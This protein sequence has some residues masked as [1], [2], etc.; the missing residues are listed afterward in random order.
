MPQ[1][2][3]LLRFPQEQLLFGKAGVP[4]G[5]VCGVFQ[6]NVSREEEPADGQ[7]LAAKA[8]RL[9]PQLGYAKRTS[10]VEPKEREDRP[11]HGLSL[12]EIGR[13][14]PEYADEIGGVYQALAARD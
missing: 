1:V 7:N 12:H 10:H 8:K 9:A 4:Q 5:N 14:N 3:S 13:G 6:G 2:E 11:A